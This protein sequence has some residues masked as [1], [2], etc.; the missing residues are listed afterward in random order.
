[1]MCA[2][3]GCTDELKTGKTYC[4]RSCA[5]KDAPRKRALDGM[6]ARLSHDAR[7]IIP[8]RV[9]G[10]LVSVL[11]KDAFPII[12]EMAVTLQDEKQLVPP[13]LKEITQGEQFDNYYYG[14]VSGR[15]ESYRPSDAISYDRVEDMLRN[16]Q[17]VFGLEMKKSWIRTALRDDRSWDIECE[18]ERMRDIVEAQVDYVMRR[19]SG[20][21]LEALPYGVYFGEKVFDRL[22][23][24]HWGLSMDE[25]IIGYKKINPVYP[26]SIQAILYSGKLGQTFNGYVQGRSYGGYARGAGDEVTVRPDL[27]LVLTYNKR[28][29]DLWGNSILEP[30]YP[31]WAWYTIAYRSW[32][33]YLERMGT[34]VTICYAPQRGQV[35][36]PDGTAVHSM[37]YA[38]MVAGN[39]SKS[40]AVAIPSDV[41]PDTGKQLWRVE[42]LAADARS[43]QFEMAI[44]ALGTQIIRSMIIGDRT[45]EQPVGE[46]GSNAASQTHFAVTMLHNEYV[47]SQFISQFNEYMIPQIVRYNGKQNGPR[48]VMITEGLDPDEKNRLFQLLNT[49]GNQAGGNSMNYIDWQA[50]MRINNIPVLSEEDVKEIEDDNLQRQEDQ[51]A[52]AHKYSEPLASKGVKKD[53]TNPKANPRTNPAAQKAK[54]S[55]DMAAY[56][57]ANGAQA[58]IMLSGEQAQEFYDRLSERPFVLFNPYH[59]ELGRFSS[60]SSAASIVAGSVGKKKLSALRDFA[61]EKGVPLDVAV[62]TAVRTP[63][64]YAKAKIKEKLSTKEKWLGK[65]SALDIPDYPDDFW[66]K[67]GEAIH[68]VIA[69]PAEFLARNGR[70]PKIARAVIEIGSDL[71]INQATKALVFGKAS[72]LGAWAIGALATG[73]GF[74]TA[75]LGLMAVGG[76][77]LGIAATMIIS[78]ILDKA[79][80]K[81]FY[82]YVNRFS[83]HDKNH[84]YVS[85]TAAKKAATVVKIGAAINYLPGQ[86]ANMVIF[87]MRKGIPPALAA[88]LDA[89]ELGEITGVIGGLK[90]EESTMEEETNSFVVAIWPNILQILYG[91]SSGLEFPYIEQL[92]DFPGFKK[93]ND[94]LVIDYDGALEFAKAWANDSFPVLSEPVEFG[95]MDF[96]VA[97][98]SVDELATVVDGIANGNIDMEDD[99]YEL[100]NPHHDEL[101][102]FTEKPGGTKTALVGGGKRTK[103]ISD[104][105]I[106][107]G[108]IQ[109]T[110]KEVVTLKRNIGSIQKRISK[111]ADGPFSL[112]VEATHSMDEFRKKANIPRGQ[113]PYILGVAGYGGKLYVNPNA[114]ESLAGRNKG[115][116]MSGRYGNVEFSK[117]AWKKMSKH[118][119]THETFHGRKRKYPIPYSSNNRVGRDW[120]IFMEEGANELLSD[121]FNVRAGI[122]NMQDVKKLGAYKPYSYTM[123]SEARARYPD[124]PEKAVAWVR[125]A[126]KTGFTADG[127]GESFGGTYKSNG[128]PVRFG[129]GNWP[130]GKIGSYDDLKWIIDGAASGNVKLEDDVTTQEFYRLLID[131]KFAEARALA[132]DELTPERAWIISEFLA[133]SPDDVRE[134][135]DREYGDGERVPDPDTTD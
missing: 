7:Q 54:M 53:P 15:K 32:L 108:D 87:G 124:S 6:K 118:V 121:V 58:P 103:Y 112:D 92:V 59:D 34:P 56:A 123:A 38:F 12:E 77:V 62:Q 57:L 25:K 133:K 78:E 132:G 98:E 65:G 125:E 44:K 90:L 71:A 49:M 18:D 100:F 8:D 42:Y 68:K 76:V 89:I 48:A 16:G 3:P 46:G 69:A 61:K 55:A 52:M 75:P 99:T 110:D 36:D 104:V 67:T 63:E 33:R 111:E 64:Y 106:A 79:Q 60:K 31:F 107:Q 114:V 19:H 128:R 119:I 22:P 29:R 94:M 82:S 13:L 135:F 96:T 11:G 30:V 66:G 80:D 115:H 88:F 81:A 83:P 24:Q 14:L 9:T 50:I 23:A 86:I 40:N 97:E 17:C 113:A 1:M 47:L 84:I 2:R 35:R 45:A 28:F 72:V 85:R 105:D 127:V 10:K 130:P 27:A 126:H 95:D 39:I 26:R 129:G 91:T 134:R 20:E 73:L 117:D 120:N 70:I 4:S 5:R 122:W 51:M 109:L 93:E 21:F 74:A 37:K 41:D 101:G 131:G 116:V 43:A 102:R